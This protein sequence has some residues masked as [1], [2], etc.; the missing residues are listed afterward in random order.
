M[1]QA[2]GQSFKSEAPF[3]ERIFTTESAGDWKNPTVS[4]RPQ[5]ISPSANFCYNWQ[6]GRQA[7]RPVT[8]A[9]WGSQKT[10]FDSC[11]RG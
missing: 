4:P 7:S 10:T 9:D 3:G 5:P 6:S 11:V 8:M 1:G 2:V